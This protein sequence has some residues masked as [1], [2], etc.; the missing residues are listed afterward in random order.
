MGFEIS[1]GVPAESYGSLLSSILMNKLPPEICLFVSRVIGGGSW[2]LGKLL[3]TLEEKLQ[4]RK[5]V[6]TI[7]TLLHR[8]KLGDPLPLLL[9]C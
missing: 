3:E 5:R 7:V 1:I 6:V 4:A 2:E 8:G 9:H